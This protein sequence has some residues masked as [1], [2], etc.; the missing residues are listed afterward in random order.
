MFDLFGLTI[1]NAPDYVE[2]FFFYM[3]SLGLA[4][5][6]FNVAP[7]YRLDGEHALR[8]AAESYNISLGSVERI[9]KVGTLL[10]ITTISLALINLFLT[11]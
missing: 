1:E 7:V 5:A 2:S 8:A 6:M 9:L 11:F 4:M 10:T 3:A